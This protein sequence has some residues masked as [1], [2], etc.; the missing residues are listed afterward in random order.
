MSSSELAAEAP[1]MLGPNIPP[2]MEQRKMTAGAIQNERRFEA[3]GLQPPS[4]E[5]R[6]SACPGQRETRLSF[7]RRCQNRKG[8]ELCGLPNSEQGVTARARRKRFLTF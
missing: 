5:Y 3:K 7:F 1:E 6:H 8:S 4:I 2:A